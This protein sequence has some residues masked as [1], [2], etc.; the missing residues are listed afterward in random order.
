M[1]KILL[2]SVLLLTI[3]FFGCKKDNNSFAYSLNDLYGEWHGTDVYVD[4]WVDITKYPFTKYAFSIKFYKDGTYYGSGYFGNGS[5]TYKAEKKT[6]Y[7]YVNGKEYY[8]YD[9][10]EW[11]PSNKTAELIMSDSKSSIPIKVK[12]N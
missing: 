12:K 5:G 8:K 7:T 6:I 2:L 10:K 4:G 1:K 3:T 11:N 9:I